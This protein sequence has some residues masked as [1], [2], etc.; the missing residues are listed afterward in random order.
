MK[1]GIRYIRI[2]KE[3]QSNFSIS[4]QQLFTQ[5]WF[6]RTETTLVDTF[7]DDGF[8]A[9]NFDRPDWAKL[10]AFIQKHHKT[11]DYLVLNSF[12]RISRD[13]GEA[14]VKIKGLHRK[15]GISVVSVTQNII[16]DANDAG[17]AFTTGLH[18]L[19]AEDEL[20]RH[21]NRVNQ[22]IYTGK[23]LEGR[24]L[25]QAPFGYLNARDDSKKPI[26]ILDKGKA[27]IISFIFEA[28]LKDTPHY[29]ILE[30]AK[31]MGFNKKG[32]N[33]IN[34]ILTNPVYTGL[35]R[36]K[37]FKEMPGGLFEGSHEAIIERRLWVNVQDKLSGRHQPKTLIVDTMPL[38][39]ILK[40]HCGVPLTGAP[41][42][43]KSGKYWE[44]YKCKLKGHNNISVTKAHEKLHK[45]FELMSL[46]KIMIAAIKES[47]SQ[48]MEQ[49]LAAHSQEASMQKRKLA[50]AT[51]QLFSVEEKW[52]ANQMPFVTYEKWN[53]DLS[54]KISYLTME[55]ERLTQDQSQSWLLLNTELNKLGDLNY[56]YNC[57]TTLQ[58]QEL[59]NLVFDRGLYFSKPTYRTPYIMPIFATNYNKMKELELLIL[60]ENKKTSP[61]AGGVEASSF[62]SN[63]FLILDFVKLI[64]A[65]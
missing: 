44:Y 65:A 58:K 25:H 49:Q 38:R 19:L 48:V 5:Q 9:Q 59:V 43:G 54:N 12:D 32:N 56:I 42:R 33:Y 61:K 41:S 26:I 28:Y 30:E 10:E 3:K 21:K 34:A 57:S 47:S 29:I 64:K 40:C 27:H 4:G 11:I 14:L 8:T 37:A 7:I 6:D 46:S 62:Q 52:I 1:K 16:Y 23:K 13:A 63:L 39:G 18:M 45:I 24:F 31:A 20:I 15:F 35:I 36:V 22:G 60:D 17:S 50:D 55:I 51:A 2:S 53:N